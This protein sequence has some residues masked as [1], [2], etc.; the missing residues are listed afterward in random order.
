MAELGATLRSHSRLGNVEQVRRLLGEGAPVDAASVDGY[1]A[2]IEA[3]FR[4]RLD[5][6]KFLVESGPTS[7][8]ALEAVGLLS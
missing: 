2:L 1:P 4:G 8:P 3:A 5:V 7:I 6:V